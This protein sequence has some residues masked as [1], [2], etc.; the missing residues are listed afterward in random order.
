MPKTPIN[1]ALHRPYNASLHQNRSWIHFDVRGEPSLSLGVRQ[2]MAPAARRQDFSLA[3][4]LAC[5]LLMPGSRTAHLTHPRSTTPTMDRLI[6]DITLEIFAQQGSKGFKT[7][8]ALCYRPPPNPNIE[9]LV[10]TIC[11]GLTHMS[12]SLP[13]VAWNIVNEG[14][15]TGH[16]GCF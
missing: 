6:P 10:N 13:W 11:Q 4:S 7:P 16:L 2:A 1:N 15:T 8:F 9:S 12:A 5:G 14:S 3:I